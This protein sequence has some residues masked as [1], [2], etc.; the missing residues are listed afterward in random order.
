M[1]SDKGNMNEL[2]LFNKLPVSLCFLVFHFFYLQ[3]FVNKTVNKN[4]YCKVPRITPRVN[5]KL[6]RI[7]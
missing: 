2:L 7:S 4:L 1:T 3:T 6:V 5:K